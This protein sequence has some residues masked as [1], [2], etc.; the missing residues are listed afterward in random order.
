VSEFLEESLGI[1]FGRILGEYDFA[2]LEGCQ[3][4]Q[5]IFEDSPT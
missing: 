4:A 1:H 3:R 2:F 5:F